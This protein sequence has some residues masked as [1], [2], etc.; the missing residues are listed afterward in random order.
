MIRNILRVILPLVVLGGGGYGAYRLVASYEAPTT[1]PPVVEVPFVRVIEAE[2]QRINLVVNTEGTVTPRTESTLVPEVSGRV[3]E[4]SPSL[5]AGGFFEKGEPLLHID[6]REYD[7]AVIRARSAIAQAKLRL[8]TEQQEADVARKAWQELGEGEANPLVLREPQLEEV[9]AALASAEAS[10]EQA[11]YDLERTVVVAP[12]S[13]RVRQKSVDRGQYVQKGAPVATLYSVD[14]A[15]VRLPIP[16]EELAYLSLSLAYRGDDGAKQTGPRVKLTAQFAGRS[17]SWMGRIVRTDAEIDPQTR[18][19]QAIAQVE[20]PYAP[21]AGRGKPPLAVGMFV[22]AEVYGRSMRVIP[23]PRAA[24]RGENTVLVVNDQ[25]KIEFRE[26]TIA[27]RE[28]DRVLVTSGVKPGEKICVS[29]LETA[30]AG[31]PVRLLQS[32]DREGA[33]ND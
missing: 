3:I 19:I 18:M 21:T 15:E 33:I 8:A 28:R 7:L 24:I 9:R 10:L 11:E 25:N 12:Y 6:T 27:R 20:D 31:M 29:V 16:D 14:V 2:S 32:R 22:Q 30:V 4:I 5:A 23:L 26:L 13:G 1:A 17:H